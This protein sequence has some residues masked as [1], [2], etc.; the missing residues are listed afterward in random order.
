MTVDATVSTW[1][2]WPALNREAEAMLCDHGIERTL[3]LT[4]VEQVELW[5]DG[6]L[7][8]PREWAERSMAALGREWEDV[9]PLPRWSRMGL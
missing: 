5:A 4:P 3:E 8:D 7:L 1:T 9:G 2:D 6:G